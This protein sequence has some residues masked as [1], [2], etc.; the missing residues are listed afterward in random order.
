MG[1][2]DLGRFG[3]KG[4]G[5]GAGE[6]G[7][8]GLLDGFDPEKTRLTGWFSGCETIFIFGGLAETVR[9]CGVKMA[10]QGRKKEAPMGRMLTAKTGARDTKGE[11]RVAKWNSGS[12]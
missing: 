7:A 5:V 9:F 4:L 10:S 3:G 12:H 2:L 1:L 8:T 6:R 11:A